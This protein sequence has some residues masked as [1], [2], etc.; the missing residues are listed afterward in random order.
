MSLTIEKYIKELES[1]KITKE[2][3]KDSKNYHASSMLIFA[4]LNRL[5][6]LG[7]EIITAEE[8]GAPN[9]YQD[10]MTILIKGNILNKEQGE[11]INK[12]LSK[13]NAFAHFYGEITE[14][15][16]YDTILDLKEVEAFLKTIKKRV[17]I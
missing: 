5:I 3:L 14:K 16:V 6:D 15:E 9:T 4:I 13:R 10:I 12:L 17:K 2:N 11:K 1:Y 7:S 8:L